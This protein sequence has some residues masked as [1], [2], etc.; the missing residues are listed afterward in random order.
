[1]RWL[2]EEKISQTRVQPLPTHLVVTTDAS[3]I[4]GSNPDVGISVLR[5]KSPDSEN[6]AD[7][8]TP[9]V[10]LDFV[11]GKNDYEDAT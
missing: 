2:I 4:S 6:I 7:H 3:K 5:V 9:P 8:I 1:M 11:H 10:R